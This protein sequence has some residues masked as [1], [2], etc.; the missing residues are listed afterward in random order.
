MKI[1]GST[2]FTGIIGYPVEHTLSP[3]MQ[4]AAF[5]KVG[6]NW[7]Y[8]PFNVPPEEVKEA[9]LGL[10]VC[11][12]RGLNVTM[13][14]KQDVFNLVDSVEE[15]ARLLGMVNT[16]EFVGSKL[17]GHNTDG[18]GFLKSLK[19]EGSFDPAGKAC[20]IIGAGGVG[21]SIAL[22][23]ASSGAAE[24]KVLNRTP[25]KAENIVVQINEQFSGCEGSIGDIE[26]PAELVDY[27]LIV[28]ATS[29]GMEANPGLPVT[30]DALESWQ[31]VYDVIYRP[32]ETDFLKEAKDKGAKV[33]NGTGMLLNQGAEAF[34]IWTGLHAPIEKMAA[35]LEEELGRSENKEKSAASKQSVG[36]DNIGH[37][38]GHSRPAKRGQGS[39]KREKSP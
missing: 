1:N 13:P 25:E 15:S 23:L 8:L 21:Q 16:V 14:H 19:V 35:A 32:S 28:N 24:I 38:T 31:I 9:L 17:V 26:N 34:S 18:L 2:V 10:A 20:L 37:K 27:D 7:K 39:R 29:V 12:C 22:S 30:L 4:N 3:A 36:K 6:L 5:N 11:G 33:I